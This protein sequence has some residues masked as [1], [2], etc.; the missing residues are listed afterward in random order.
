MNGKRQLETTRLADSPIH[1]PSNLLRIG[2]EQQLDAVNVLIGCR[3][4]M[5]V[6]IHPE[7]SGL[8]EP[9]PPPGD[10]IRE[11][12]LSVDRR[13]CSPESLNRLEAPRQG[14]ST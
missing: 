13:G 1:R 2:I 7:A 11:E 6:L 4:E 5:Q 8:G 9:D 3:H 14:R 12:V 10:G